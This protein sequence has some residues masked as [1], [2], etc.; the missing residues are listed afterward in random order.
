M[1]ESRSL[2]VMA[3][4]SIKIVATP[5]VEGDKECISTNC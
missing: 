1:K 2:E 3:G 4:E 5:E